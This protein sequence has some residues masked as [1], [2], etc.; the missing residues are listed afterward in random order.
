MTGRLAH[1]WRYPIKS[2]GREPLERISV[3]A[4]QTLPWDRTWA[5]AH[6]AAKTDGRGWAPCANFTRG[7]KAPGLMAIEASLDEK[8]ESVRLA[9][10]DKEPLEFSPDSPGDLQSFL[11]WSAD[12][13]PENRARSARILRIA[14]RGMT[15][16]DYP[17]VSLGNLSSL[18]DLSDR[19]GQPLDPRRFR[20]NFWIEGLKPWEEFGWVGQEIGLGR[21]RFFVEERIQRCLAT[22]ANPE[23]GRR[24]ADTLGALKAGWGHQDFGVYLTALVTGEL[25]RG[26]PL[27]TPS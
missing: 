5:V 18:R 6:E 4:G 15:D 11:D 26:D 19:L 25:T 20:A 13:V 17:S 22:S 3:T 2:H 7:S 10:P 8:S 9:H 21:L 14:G 27:E 24:D 16:T 23:T 1:I 12:L